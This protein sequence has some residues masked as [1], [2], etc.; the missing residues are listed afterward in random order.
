MVLWGCPPHRGYLLVSSVSPEEHGIEG[1]VPRSPG[2]PLVGPAQ[3]PVHLPH[4]GEGLLPQRVRDRAPVPV[5]WPTPLCPPRRPPSLPLCLRRR[6]RAP[7]PLRRGHPRRLRPRRG[8]GGTK[9]EYTWT[10]KRS[11]SFEVGLRQPRFMKFDNSLDC[12]DFT[13]SLSK[14]SKLSQPL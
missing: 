2:G 6:C 4:Q 12:V 9:M 7:P 14:G 1:P 11:R 13:S 10:P 8:G 5:P 3:P